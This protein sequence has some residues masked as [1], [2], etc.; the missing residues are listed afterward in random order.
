MG[1]GGRGGVMPKRLK[2]GSGHYRLGICGPFSG[3]HKIKSAPH[4][5]KNSAL[6]SPDIRLTGFT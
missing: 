1:A 5:L 2:S 6:P 4:V 3:R